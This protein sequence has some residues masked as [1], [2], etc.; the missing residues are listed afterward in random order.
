MYHH[1]QCIKIRESNLTLPVGQPRSNDPQW[2]LEYL[3][4][5]LGGKKDVQPT[6]M[7]KKHYSQTLISLHVCVCISM[8]I[9]IFFLSFLSFCKTSY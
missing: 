4:L 9:Y 2:V 8:C 1:E 6:G 3:Q 7:T 5:C